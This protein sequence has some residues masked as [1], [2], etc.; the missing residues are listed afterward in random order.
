M[1]AVVRFSPVIG[2]SSTNSASDGIVYSAL[3]TESSAVASHGLRY[4]TMASGRLMA[5]PI[6]TGSAVR[7]MWSTSSS[8]MSSRWSLIQLHLI[9]DPSRSAP[10]VRASQDLPRKGLLGQD[11]LVAVAVAD[12]HGNAGT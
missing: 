11:A 9:V 2:M 5:R 3:V 10:A 12:A 7:M 6:T 4:A 1:T 8:T